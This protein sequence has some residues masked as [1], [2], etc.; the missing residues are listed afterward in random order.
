MTNET[1]STEWHRYRKRDGVMACTKCG[2]IKGAPMQPDNDCPGKFPIE[3]QRETAR[4]LLT[5]IKKET[6]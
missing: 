1:P 5:R 2:L 4:A 6:E 3:I